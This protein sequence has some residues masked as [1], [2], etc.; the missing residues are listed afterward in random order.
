MQFHCLVSPCFLSTPVRNDP[1][2]CCCFSTRNSSLQKTIRA[3][4]KWE[5]TK[6]A[7]SMDSTKEVLLSSE[8]QW[9][10]DVGHLMQIILILCR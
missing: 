9:D 8:S 7:Q 2:E 3:A 1:P 6:S 10:Q 5:F 4:F